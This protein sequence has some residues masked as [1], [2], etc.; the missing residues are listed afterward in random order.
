MSCYSRRVSCIARPMRTRLL[1]RLV[2]IVSVLGGLGVS[3]LYYAFLYP[4]GSEAVVAIA[5]VSG[6]VWFATPSTDKELGA[7]G[8]PAP[9]S[10]PG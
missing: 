6:F 1:N 2:P 8:S 5:T 3:L 9:R 7:E 4:F 10:G